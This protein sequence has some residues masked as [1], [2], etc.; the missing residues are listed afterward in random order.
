MRRWGRT[1]KQLLNNLKDKRRYGNLKY[2]APD[3]TLWRTRFGRGCD[4]S[5][6]Q[7][8]EW[9]NKTDSPFLG[10]NF[11]D[12]AVERVDYIRSTRQNLKTSIHY[13]HYY[14]HYKLHSLHTLY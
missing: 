9:L 3:R 6:R 5:L 1:R 13:S 12:N 10:G 11:S 2:E 4:L 8:T 14:T 7:T